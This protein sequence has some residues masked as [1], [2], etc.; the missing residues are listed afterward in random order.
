[1]V[2]LAPNMMPTG[3]SGVLYHHLWVLGSSG[4]GQSVEGLKDGTY[5]GLL[6]SCP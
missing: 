3:A 2:I 6:N 1:M 4:H 5:E